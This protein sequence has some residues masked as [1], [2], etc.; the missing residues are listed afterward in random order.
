MSSTIT[1]LTVTADGTATRTQFGTTGED[2]GAALADMQAAVGGYIES[3]TLRGRG[4]LVVYCDEEGKI[5]GLPYNERA[6]EILV[7]LGWTGAEDDFPVG[8][9]VFLGLDPERGV[10]IDLPGDVLAL[11]DTIR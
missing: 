11:A 10:E 1:A 6:H 4:D 7:R 2:D 9:I 3:I 5:K 8:T